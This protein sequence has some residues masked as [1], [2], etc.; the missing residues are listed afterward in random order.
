MRKQL[1][2]GLV[3]MCLNPSRVLGQ[4][5]GDKEALRGVDS[6]G[7]DIHLQDGTGELQLDQFKTIVELELRKIG[8]TVTD[9]CMNRLI[10]SV[11]VLELERDHKLSGLRIFN[12][13][14]AFAQPVIAFADSSPVFTLGYTWQ[15]GFLGTPGNQLLSSTIERHCKALT[16]RFLNDYLAAN[17]RTSDPLNIRSK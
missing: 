7:V 1:M 15:N 11:H 12:C 13:E 2:I 10:F 8:V 3:I 14:L 9:D 6:I 16:D 5:F 17:P 4:S